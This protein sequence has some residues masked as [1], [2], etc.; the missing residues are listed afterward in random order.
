MLDISLDANVELYSSYFSSWDYARGHSDHIITNLDDLSTFRQWWTP[1]D[2]NTLFRVASNCNLCESSEQYGDNTV[3][4]TDGLLFCFGQY[5]GSGC[6]AIDGPLNEYACNQCDV[7]DID[8]QGYWS[9]CSALQ[10]SSDTPI[11]HDQEQRVA[12]GLVYR[13][14]M[15]FYRDACTCYKPD[16]NQVVHH[17]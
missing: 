15:S 9:R 5:P 13:P 1:S 16:D 4:Y 14:V 2:D 8:E 12:H 17:L 7:G 10:M 3:Y 11:N 6:T